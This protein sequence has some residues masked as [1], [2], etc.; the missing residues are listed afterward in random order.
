MRETWSLDSLT[1]GPL[2]HKT[3]RTLWH[4]GFRDFPA[5]PQLKEFTIVYYFP[6][7]GVLDATCWY[8]FNS[9]LGREDIFPRSMH[10]DIRIT[11]GSAP[12]S[13]P[14]KRTMFW[15]LFSSLSKYKLVK[16]CGSCEYSY[17]T[18]CHHSHSTIAQGYWTQ[19]M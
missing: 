6:N 12:L 13:P 4:D 1:I 16:F 19:S 17:S 11:V 15:T 5:L 14:R 8:S 18:L 2:S 10:V 3:G 7:D 9:F